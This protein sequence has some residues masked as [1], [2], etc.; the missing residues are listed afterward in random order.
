MSTTQTGSN[1]SP[2]QAVRTP[3]ATYTAG[4]TGVIQYLENPHGQELL[5]LNSCFVATTQSTGA[6]TLDI[7]VAANAT[8]SSDT[9]IDGMSAATAGVL[10]TRGTN[11]NYCRRWGATEVITIN[12]ASGDVAGLVG[13]LVVEYCIVA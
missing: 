7:G 6:A 3:T 5:I 4:S 13:Y 10:Q 1:R 12:E 9:M 11:G 8:T 2:V